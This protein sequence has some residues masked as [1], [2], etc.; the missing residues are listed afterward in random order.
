MSP[1]SCY[2]HFIGID[3]G[4]STFVAATELEGKSVSFSNTSEGFECFYKQYESQL[5]EGLVVVENTG[6]YEYALVRF[7]LQHQIAVH[8]AHARQVKSFIA[9]LGTTAKTDAL[10][11]KGLRRYA[12]ERHA[13]LR[14]MVLEDE[15]RFQ[16]KGLT[17]RRQELVT[18]RAQEKNR[19]QSPGMVASVR[20][21]VEEHIEYLTQAIE[22]MDEAIEVVFVQ[23]PHLATQRKVLE[24]V[25]GIGK[26]TATLLLAQL[27]ELGTIDRRAIAALTGT[28]PFARDSGTLKGYRSTWGGRTEVK[29][30]LFIAALSAARSHSLL[31]EYYQDLI[32]RGKHKMVAL[33]ALMRKIIV[34]A[35]ARLRDFF[36]QSEPSDVIALAA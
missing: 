29:A 20:M 18:M 3:I 17:A 12:E 9:S 11:A 22:R 21:N 7:L 24:T 36:L 13:R 6:G 28:A 32:A 1:I 10:D 34:I 2:R 26:V 33:V 27:E 30:A 14:C 23:H 35:N 16:L 5:K 15:V 25:P 8:R 19:Y 31:G 4:K